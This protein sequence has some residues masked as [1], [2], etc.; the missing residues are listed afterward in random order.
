MPRKNK[1]KD[2]SLAR[3]PERAPLSAKVVEL[4]D[5]REPEETRKRKQERDGFGDFLAGGSEQ[6]LERVRLAKL[7]AAAN[8]WKVIMNQRDVMVEA[9]NVMAE[10]L[11][12]AKAA[13][14][15]QKFLKRGRK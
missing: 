2:D 11:G 8:A 5:E 1:A 6:T 4:L 9:L 15:I 13:E 14:I 10:A 7:N 3:R 12:D